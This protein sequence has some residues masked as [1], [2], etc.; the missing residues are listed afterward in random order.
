MRYCCFTKETS[1]VTGFVEKIAFLAKNY[2]KIFKNLE[3]FEKFV[4]FRKIQIFREKFENFEILT[5]EFMK[6][7]PPPC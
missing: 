4:F 6:N 2:L 3:K 5:L 7:A 1:N